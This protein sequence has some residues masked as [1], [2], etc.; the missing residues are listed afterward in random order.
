MVVTRALR[1]ALAVIVLSLLA[2]A[3]GESVDP[4]HPTPAQVRPRQGEDLFGAWVGASSPERMLEFERWTGRP[5]TAVHSFLAHNSWGAMERH[6]EWA[7]R[8]WNG[9]GRQ[10]VFSV[11]MLAED[12]GTLRQGAAGANDHRFR[13]LAQLLV[14]NGQKRAI[15]RLGWEFNL[16]WPPW[17]AKEDPAA[18]ADYWRRIVKVM[19]SVPGASG[20]RF[21]WCPGSGADVP[22]AAYPGDAYVDVIGMDVYDQS[23]SP[24]QADPVA[25]WQMLRDRP[26]G[27]LE[28]QRNFAAAH[29]K[30]ISYPEWAV[31]EGPHVAGASPDNSYFI[32]QMARWIADNNV[33]YSLYFNSD[34]GG[35]HKLTGGS[36]P[37]AATAFRQAF[38]R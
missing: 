29:G 33:S 24:R 26:S 22:S 23:Y 35:G 38:G 9:T 6:A 5:V 18:F 15:I 12:G 32:R 20:L 4:R 1:L 3:C 13:R 37:Q 19:R 28:W 11:P 8:A 10:T 17:S 36:F 21:D 30:P 25:R 27:G 14:Q 2:S 31:S 34:G 16:K 7:F